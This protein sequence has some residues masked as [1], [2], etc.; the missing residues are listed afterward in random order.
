LLTGQPTIDTTHELVTEAAQGLH[1]AVLRAKGELGAGAFK[2]GEV[3]ARMQE[4]R[5]YTALGFGT[6]EDYLAGEEVAL[7]RATA[8]RFIRVFRTYGHVVHGRHWARDTDLRKLDI[9]SRLIDE[10]TDPAQVEAL[11]EQARELPREELRAAVNEEAR[12]RG[13]LPP[14]EREAGPPALR[15]LARE[16][17]QG[18]AAAPKP[19]PLHPAIPDE[20][21]L[22]SMMQTEGETFA[23]ALAEGIAAD[24]EYHAAVLGREFMGIAHLLHRAAY[25]NRALWGH[26]A[27][28]DLA[29]VLPREELARYTRDYEERIK[30]LLAWYEQ[31][32]ALGRRGGV[33]RVK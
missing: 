17:P 15:S 6:F 22:G 12:R 5:A 16:V 18:Q 21:T 27:P 25:E 13:V 20:P 8:Y 31:V 24:P 14:G 23:A 4:S 1:R 32:L 3:L 29:R 11:V 2:L 19:A 10:G 28:E 30:P 7:H 26:T 33:Q 9:L